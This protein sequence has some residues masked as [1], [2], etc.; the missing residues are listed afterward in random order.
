MIFER[1]HFKSSRIQKSNIN[2]SLSESRKFSE[3]GYSL[4]KYDSK[5]TVFI[6][7]K[8]SDLADHKELEG[9]IEL[10]DDLGAKVYID[11][12]DNGMP[13]ETS[14]ETALRIKEVIKY[15]DKFILIATEKAI[16]SYWC[17]WELGFGDT[18]KYIE[19]IAI[20][21]IK[22]KGEYD[23][24]YKGNEYL[25]IYPSIDY[26]DGTNRY[27]NSRELI[28]KGYYVCKPKNKEGIRYITSLKKWLNQ[29]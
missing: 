23:H 14:G 3:K 22:E 5:P 18:H 17:N 4:R 24:N 26:E 25:Q 20:L 21:P 19:H 2:E 29:Q 7:H 15:C 12:M 13:T 9:V 8:H 1:G 27:R 16:E 10:L 28:P 11:S 6:S